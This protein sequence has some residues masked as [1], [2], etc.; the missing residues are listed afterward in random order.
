MVFSEETLDKLSDIYAYCTPGKDRGIEECN[1]NYS[2]AI[3]VI[4]TD[5]LSGPDYVMQ[6]VYERYFYLLNES[7]IKE[8]LNNRHIERIVL[9]NGKKF[10]RSKKVNI[11]ESMVD[12]DIDLANMDPSYEN[13]CI[14]EL[15]NLCLDVYNRYKEKTPETSFTDTIEEFKVGAEK[16]AIQGMLQSSL[17]V[18]FKGKKVGKEYLQGNDVKDFLKTT[19]AQ[20]DEKYGQA[21][22]AQTNLID[23]YE[24]LRDILD[25]SARSFRRVTDVGIPPIDEA[26]SDLHTGQILTITG[27][28]G[29]GKSRITNR[30]IYRARVFDK[31]NCYMWSGE[32]T[33]FEILCIQLA[34]H[35]WYAFETYIDDKMIKMYYDTDPN[36]KIPDDLKLTDSDIEVLNNAELDFANGDYGC[37]YIEDDT[38]YVEDFEAKMMYLKKKIDLDLFAIDYLLLMSSNGKNPQGKVLNKTEMI[39]YMMAKAKGVAKKLLMLGIVLNQLDKET[40]KSI[41]AGNNA[42]VTASKYSSA[43]VDFAD[44]NLVVSNDEAMYN[45]RKVKFH[46]PKVRSGRR[47]KPFIANENAG[48][49][50]YKYLEED[51]DED[52]I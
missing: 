12:F 22:N 52:A 17:E 6:L 42:T 38:L 47:F 13:K 45:A 9:N 1:L 31:K 44:F 37:L 18:F 11:K 36:K 27:S 24:S 43:P 50:D 7:G 25:N 14:N 16:D 35:C 26:F 8:P 10:L 29:A 2:R 20:V 40:I 33:R 28:P 23:S 3:Q 51:T 21:E 34:Q 15:Y 39:E 19:L 46:C 41:L 4:D 32:M 49:C 5:M 48:V 30:I